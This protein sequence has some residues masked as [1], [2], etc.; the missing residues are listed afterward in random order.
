MFLTYMNTQIKT[1]DEKTPTAYN[2]DVHMVTKLN[3]RRSHSQ[4]LIVCTI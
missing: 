3:V 4:S 1:E 2:N